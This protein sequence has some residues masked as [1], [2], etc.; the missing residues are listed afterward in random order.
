[1]SGPGPVVIRWSVNPVEDAPRGR[2]TIVGQRGKAILHM[3]EAD[4]WRLETRCDGQEDTESFLQWNAAA[5]ALDELAAA[6]E[7]DA[8][9]VDWPQAARAVE[10]AETIDRSLAKGRTI[11]LYNEEF[12]DIG[13]FKGTMTS[14]GCGLLLA[15]LCAMLG[16]GVIELVARKQ[17]AIKLADA[18]RFWPYWLVGFLLVFL[19]IQLILKLATSERDSSKSSGSADETSGGG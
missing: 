17:G 4:P 18:L 19:L 16:I 10:L 2:L 8:Q 15:G 14:L 11:E 1:M 9:H 12:T 6:I 7:G 5:T 13:T 3:P